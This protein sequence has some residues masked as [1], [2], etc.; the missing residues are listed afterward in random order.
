MHRHIGRTFIFILG[1]ALLLSAGFASDADAAKRKFSKKQNNSRYASLVIDATTGHV[2]HEEN[3]DALRYPASLTKMMTM[4]MLFS[5]LKTGQLHMDSRLNVSEKA[6]RMPETNIN[7]RKG[8]TITVREAIEA[9][10]VRSAN[11]VAVVVAENLGNTEWNFA[12]MMTA[13]ARELGMSRTVFR[14][15]SGLPDTRQL[16]TAKDMAKLAIALRKNFP[17]Y[18]HYFK[19]RSFRHKGITYTS[20]NR[21]LNRYQG[22]DGIKTGYINASGFN[23]VTTVKR[24]GYTLVGVVFGG[25]TAQRRDDHMIKLLN[26]GMVMMAKGGAPAT[27]STQYASAIPLPKTNPWR[28][29]ETAS[30]QP[31]VSDAAP[32]GIPAPAANPYRATNTDYSTKVSFSSIAPASGPGT[33]RGW[34][35][36]VGAFADARQALVAATNAMTL[37]QNELSNSRI[38][39][40]DAD[41]TW[42][43]I[44]RARLA[45]L[46]EQ[47]ARTACQ[48]LAA[49]KASCFVYRMAANES[50]L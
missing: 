11:D 32:A 31:V 20:H 33:A 41:A 14:N 43:G 2:L 24:D 40:S 4:Y 47:Q 16:T 27:T 48:K 13:K 50:E 17:D 6:A 19:T 38:A 23:L 39:V 18:F 12:V 7:L 10:V 29:F 45:E 8:E 46:T 30:V 15:A 34:G 36:Q 42:A 21:V 26:D 25:T 37:A 1:L 5:A 28:G 22:A 44:H 9:L 35:I 3:A 49:S